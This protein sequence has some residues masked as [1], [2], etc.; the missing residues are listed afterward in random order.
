[1]NSK[2]QQGQQR[3]CRPEELSNLFPTVILRRHMKDAKSRNKRIRKIVLERE[4]SD[5]GV[6]QSNVGGWHS[7][8][9]LWDWP[10]PE[11]RDLCKWVLRSGEDLT[12]SMFPLQ[13]GDEVKAE[14]YGGAWANVL[15][16]GG[17]NKVH[18][19]PGAVWS[20][21]YYVASGD[22]YPDPPG[23]GNF[24]FMDPRP[25][26]LHG[27]K[28][29]IRPEPGLLMIFPAWL[30]HYVNAYHG[31]GERISIAWNMTVEIVR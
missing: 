27:R 23:N 7:T 5:P 9:D 13:P 25:G 20:A 11:I 28:E 10:N 19:H 22:P 17:Y 24:E 26:N 29:I 31:D 2:P 8:A 3:S 21:V 1:M 4:K 18:N 14:P 12:A 30:N 15:R 16:E 6:Q